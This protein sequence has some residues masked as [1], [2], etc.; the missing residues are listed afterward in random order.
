MLIQNIC[1]LSVIKILNCQL[2]VCNENIKKLK[3]YIPLY[4]ID[5]FFFFFFD[6]G[7]IK[8][9]EF[10]T[11]SFWWLNHLLIYCYYQ[12]LCVWIRMP[13]YT[14]IFTQRLEILWACHR[15]HG[16]KTIWK[17]QK[18]PTAPT[19][20]SKRER[21]SDFRKRFNMVRCIVCN[22]VMKSPHYIHVFIW[23][24]GLH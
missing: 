3:T 23:G 5:L 24:N 19:L 12:N 9:R 8:F 10:K 17:F 15:A 22:N 13:I 7:Y 18:Q 20:I 2:R 1:Y 4:I 14:Y 16:S 21:K 6:F 11:S